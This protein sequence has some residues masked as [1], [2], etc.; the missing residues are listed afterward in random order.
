MTTIGAARPHLTRR[1]LPFGILAI[2]ARS[3]IIQGSPSREDFERVRSMR[4]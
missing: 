2:M 4:I 1:V 3:S